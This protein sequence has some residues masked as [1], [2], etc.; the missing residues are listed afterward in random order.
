M[1]LRNLYILAGVRL[2]DSVPVFWTGKAGEGWVTECVKDA[3]P[4]S[5]ADI[6]NKIDLFNSRSSLNGIYWTDIIDPQFHVPSEIYER[7][8]AVQAAIRS[9]RKDREGV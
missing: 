6:Q 4:A 9:A 1:E 3:Y 7:H 5:L 8:N 2:V